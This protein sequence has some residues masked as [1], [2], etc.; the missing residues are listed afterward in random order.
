MDYV[1][2]GET[3]KITDDLLEGVSVSDNYTKDAFILCIKKSRV[4]KKYVGFVESLR[5]KGIDLSF[6]DE[7]GVSVLLHAF[8]AKI[9]NI[10]ADIF[11]TN[12]FT[13]EMFL[14]LSPRFIEAGFYTLLAE[15][16]ER[17]KRERF[18]LDTIKLVKND[19]DALSLL[20]DDLEGV[21]LNKIDSL[22]N[23]ALMCAILKGYTGTA[24]LQLC[25]Y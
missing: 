23:S 3:D 20:S 22:G 11:K 5:I 10:V 13:E 1:L 8:T 7:T 17:Y 21:D 4:D 24:M 2:A 18:A 16:S 25:Y 12:S 19:S 6:A 14:R 15:H 9:E